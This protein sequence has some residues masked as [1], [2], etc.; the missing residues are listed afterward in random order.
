M[1]KIFLTRGAR[2]R[3]SWNELPDCWQVVGRWTGQ[4]PEQQ[5]HQRAEERRLAISRLIT[6]SWWILRFVAVTG[7]ILLV[8]EYFGHRDG[9]QDDTDTDR[10]FWTLSTIFCGGGWLLY[11]SKYQDIK[12]EQQRAERDRVRDAETTKHVLDSEPNNFSDPG[13]SG[14]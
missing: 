3:A 6:T 8:A 13:A 12:M 2:E 4:S 7:I 14:P 1:A 11:L 10:I 9:Q 5:A